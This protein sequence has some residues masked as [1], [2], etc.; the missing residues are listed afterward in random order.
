MFVLLSTL[1][2][3]IYKNK[4]SMTSG[5]LNAA[6]FLVLLKVKKL[7][8]ENNTQP[9][10]EIKNK[11]FRLLYTAKKSQFKVERVFLRSAS[12]LDLHVHT[13]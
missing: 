9:I 4:K 1:L 8:I 10:L 5:L 11:I 7:A 2:V 13:R 12:N 3:E 6:F